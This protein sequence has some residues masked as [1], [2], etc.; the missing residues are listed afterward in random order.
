M[1]AVFSESGRGLAGR[2][3]SWWTRGDWLEAAGNIGQFFRDLEDG[4]IDLTEEK[5][6][7]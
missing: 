1:I 7:K 6:K 3:L 5:G 4:I 2:T